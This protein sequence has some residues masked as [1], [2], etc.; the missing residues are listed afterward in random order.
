MPAATPP[1][2]GF[3]SLSTPRPAD[4]LEPQEVQTATRIKESTPVP[5]GDHPRVSPHV[6]ALAMGHS[7]PVLRMT[8][9]VRPETVTY[10]SMGAGRRESSS[11]LP[12][13]APNRFKRVAYQ[14][15]SEGLVTTAA[16][17]L[18]EALRCALIAWAAPAS[19]RRV[20]ASNIRSCS[21]TV[22]AVIP[23]A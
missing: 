14:A 8:G 9:A 15:S 6:R 16:S 2:A 19:S 20:M 3:R 23:T 1:I 11:R 17:L 7:Q 13:Q 22:S 5:E 10:R 21:R 4:G 18:R 12:D